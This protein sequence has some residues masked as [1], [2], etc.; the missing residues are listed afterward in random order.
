MKIKNESLI[1][2]KYIQYIK[3]YYISNIKKFQTL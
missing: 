3:S 1:V 2:L